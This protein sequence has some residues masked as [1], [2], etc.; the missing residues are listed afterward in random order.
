MVP[1]GN[2]GRAFFRVPFYPQPQETLSPIGEFWTSAE[3]EAQLEVA[4]WTPPG[5][6]TLVFYSRRPPV[7]VTDAERDSA[8]AEIADEVSS[9][10]GSA[11]KLDASKI[12]AYKPPLYGLSLDGRGRVWARV[13]EPK[14]D[15]TV[16]DVFVRGGRHAETVR[17]PFRVD[18][19][20]PPIT[21]GD[22]LWA[23]ITDE[24]NV[25]YVVR[26]RLRAID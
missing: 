12:P 22:T 8:V 15:S 18:A 11:V 6:T 16:Y 1:V 17:L 14:S 10:T 9:R 4:R 25:Q 7:R 23:V 5:D 13:T 21:R 2:G 19:W 26:A 3:G 20:I 24:L